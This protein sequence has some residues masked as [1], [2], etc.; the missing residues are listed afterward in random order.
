MK[1]GSSCEDDSYEISSL[2]LNAVYWVRVETQFFMGH[3]YDDD[4]MMMSIFS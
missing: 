3:T 4:M 1:D 2:I